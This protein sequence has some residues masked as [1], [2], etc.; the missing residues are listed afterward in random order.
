[1]DTELYIGFRWEIDKD[2]L[3]EIEK[4]I[5]EKFGYKDS[6]RTKCPNGHL[7]VEGEYC[8]KCGSKLTHENVRELE[9]DADWWLHYDENGYFQT[10]TTIYLGI[11]SGYSTIDVED[12]NNLKLEENDELVQILNKFA[13]PTACVFVFPW[14]YEADS[15]EDE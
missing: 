12:L 9:E 13:N 7:D 3:K 4:V 6:V 10:D 1:M 5:N 15:E 14:I 11:D 2:I 8:N